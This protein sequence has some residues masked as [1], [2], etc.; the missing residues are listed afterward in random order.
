MKRNKH[1]LHG[2]DE[3]DTEKKGIRRREGIRKED[4][5][6]LH[7]ENM[8][9]QNAGKKNTSGKKFSRHYM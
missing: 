4:G 1:R 2:E 7:T 5:E 6:A 8:A 9:E 3:D